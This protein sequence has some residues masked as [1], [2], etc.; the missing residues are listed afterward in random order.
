[1]VP[2]YTCP[3]ETVLSEGVRKTVTILFCDVVRSTSLADDVDPETLRQVMSRYFDEMRVVLE[4][5]G[6]T[7][8]KFSG[9]DVMAVFGVPV[10]H[11]DDAL[12][13]VRAASE[14]LKRLDELNEELDSIWALR[15]QVR[16]GINTGE[17]VAG[18]PSSGQTFV[19]GEPVNLAKRLEQ[20]AEPGEIFIGEATYPLVRNAVE[21]GQLE[22]FSPKGKR[23][24]VGRLRVEEVDPGAPGVAR[25]LDVPMVGRERELDQLHEAVTRAQEE[26]RCHVVT[27]LGPPGIGKSRLVAELDA[28]LSGTATVVTGRCLPYGEGITFWPLVEIVEGVGGIEA[29]GEALAG[30]EDATAV[31]ELVRGALGTAPA[32]GRSEETFWAVRRSLEALARI[33]PLVVALEDLHWAEPTFLDLLEYVL[34]WGREAPIVLV[35]LARPELVDERPAWLAPRANAT[36]IVLEPL[37]P[38]ETEALLDHLRAGTALDDE[39]CSRIATVAEGNPLFVEQMAAMAAEGNGAGSLPVPPSIHALLAERLDRLTEG[40][41][42]VIERASVIG[43]DF[44]VRAVVDLTPPDQ[45]PTIQRDL[46]SLVR[47]DL[48]RPSTTGPGPDRF[49]FR[50]VLVRDAAYGVIPKARRA[51][52]HE[53][54]AD[55][56]EDAAERPVGLDEIVGYHLEQAYRSRIDISPIDDAAEA[57]ALRAGRALATAGRR[58]S[59]RDDIPAARNLLSRAAALL[60]TEGAGRAELLLELASLSMKAGR[61]EEA[62]GMLDEASTIA[63]ESADRRLELRAVIERRYL[64]SA[65]TPEGS[66]DADRR[67]AESVIPE[68]ERLGDDVG[69]AKAWWLLSEA[70]L[71]AARWGARAE[72]LERALVHARRAGDHRQVAYLIGLLGQALLYGPTPVKQAIARCEEFL[73]DARGDLT[74]EAGTRSVLAVLRAMEGSFDEARRLWA[75]ASALYDELGLRYRRAAR[76]LVP[77]TV[78]LLAGEPNAAVVELRT[79][80]EPLEAMGELGVRSTLAAFLADALCAAG[81]YGEAEEFARVSEELAASDDLVPQIVWRCAKAKVLVQ[82]GELDDAQAL[83][84]EAEVLARQ[85]DSADLLP[86]ALESRADALSAAGRLDE[87]VPLLE[88][89]CALH[90]RKGNVVAARRTVSL[91][92]VHRG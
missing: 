40:E 62:A 60:A 24:A 11:E 6:G 39:T 75:R 61:F 83:A 46:L 34:G 37:S 80:Y 42:A 85:T 3:V 20:S 43:R 66:S 4:G 55:W 50:H 70:D 87:A 57:L 31:V 56:L 16:I 58:A 48:V 53:R 9:D 14:M 64:E 86:T 41:R 28:S 65:T 52:L 27:V 26:R 74:V 7:V 81:R 45:R 49:S 23:R 25:R 33:R 73:E 51:A 79:G 1:L 88:E 92:A 67:I 38:A 17:V 47:K 69:L 12:R 30:A 84:L 29:L 44:P 21:V 63:A 5:H 72:A 78:E 13:A 22:T 35:C 15:L 18:D 2:S 10:A 32:A 77:A 82:R 54:H 59:A 8:E 76:S 71:F 19:T 91:L 68:L 36:T 89:A 90:E